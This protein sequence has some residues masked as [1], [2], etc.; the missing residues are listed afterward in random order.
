MNTKISNLKKEIEK[1]DDKIIELEEKKLQKLKSIKKV[2]Q[3]DLD[4]EHTE[5]NTQQLLQE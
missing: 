2:K 5:Q 4:L 3:L 1:L